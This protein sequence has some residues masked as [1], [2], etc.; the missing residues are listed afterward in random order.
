MSKT[1]NISVSALLL[2]SRP[3]IMPLLAL[4]NDILV[5][6]MDFLSLICTMTG[7]LRSATFS[8]L[9][10]L[11]QHT[12]HPAHQSSLLQRCIP[13]FEPA[14]VD[15]FNGTPG[16][17]CNPLSSAISWSCCGVH[18]ARR[19]PTSSLISHNRFH[20]R[21]PHSSEEQRHAA[22]QCRQCTHNWNKWP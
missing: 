10:P 3:H 13:P 14:F 17:L 1:G 16:A 4:Y 7:L 9:T 20:N 22:G 19:N 2:S 11:L 5:N 12:P 6:E 18:V 8:A 15:I 21:P